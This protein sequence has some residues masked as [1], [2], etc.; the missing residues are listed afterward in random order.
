MEPS[1]VSIWLK[2]LDSFRVGLKKEHL[3]K[4]IVGKR[5]SGSSSRLLPLNRHGVPYASLLILLRNGLDMGLEVAIVLGEKPVG[6][7]RGLAKAEHAPPRELST[8]PWGGHCG[9][10]WPERHA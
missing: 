2:V 6:S 4:S 10:C 8:G 7:R 9:E 1:E 5:T 3:E